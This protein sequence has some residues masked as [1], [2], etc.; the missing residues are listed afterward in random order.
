MLVIMCRLSSWSVTY[1]SA[2]LFLISL[3]LGASEV[4]AEPIII[5]K[6]PETQVFEG[7][8]ENTDLV[9]TIEKGEIVAVVRQT[10]GW[11]EV[12]WLGDNGMLKGWISRKAIK[13]ESSLG[14]GSTFVS[15]GGAEF[16]LR[17]GGTGLD[18]HE[19]LF[20]EGYE[21]CSVAIPISYDSNYNGNDE[22]EVS[23][24]CELDLSLEDE[25][26]WPHKE[27]E[28]VWE[29]FYGRFGYG[30]I[31]VDISISPF[32]DAILGVKVTELN[33]RIQDVY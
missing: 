12:A 28:T 30:D 23:V 20:G 11:V 18:C 17:V 32:L 24:E 21:R 3:A 2:I 1:S 33:C 22:P 8:G 4:K 25:D 26:G 7:P 5:I 15:S 31:N 6:V 16:Q 27:T 10:D 19:R 9:G 13:I 29:S 14:G